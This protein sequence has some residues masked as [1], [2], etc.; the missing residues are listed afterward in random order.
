MILR[1]LKPENI[2]LNDKAYPCLGDFGLAKILN[3]QNTTDSFCGTEE[4]L[5]PE[6]VLRR[7]YD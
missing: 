1:D 5:S 7:S 3:E 6:R 2:L 4:Y